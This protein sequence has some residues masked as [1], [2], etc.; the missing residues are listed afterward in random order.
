MARITRAFV[1]ALASLAFLVLPTAPNLLTPSPALAASGATLPF[2]SNYNFESGPL[3]VGNGPTNYD[4]S[5]GGT[6]WTTVF[7]NVTYSGGIATLS[8]GTQLKSSDCLMGSTTQAV[9][10]RY[11]Y[12]SSASVNVYVGGTSYGGDSLAC[13]VGCNSGDWVEKYIGFSTS[14]RGLNVN[15]RITQSSGTTDVDYVGDQWIS[16]QEWRGPTSGTGIKSQPRFSGSQYSEVKGTLR[17]GDFV[18]TDNRLEFD[19]SFPV[20]T[21]NSLTAYLHRASDKLQLSFKPLSGNAIAWNRVKDWTWLPSNYVGTSVYVRFVNADDSKP[22]L[23][24]NVGINL[25]YLESRQPQPSAAAGDPFDTSAGQS[26]HSHTDMLIKGKGIPLEFRR[27]Y[28]SLIAVPGDLGYDW[29]HTYSSD[30]SPNTGPL[31]N[32]VRPV[33]AA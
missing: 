2:P 11:K 3:L 22:S 20:A 7:G 28:N 23:I 1:I 10:I 8:G 4:F 19:Y 6:G 27:F 29:R 33:L 31:I 30:L 24:D 26:G 25:V 16:L 21:G 9:K 15:V 14:A 18:L 5:S 13:P 32:A 17:T 12:P